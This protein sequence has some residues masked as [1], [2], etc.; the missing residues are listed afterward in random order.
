MSCDCIKDKNRQINALQAE[1]GRLQRALKKAKEKNASPSAITVNVAGDLD[2]HTLADRYNK[3]LTKAFRDTYALSA[4]PTTDD[5]KPLVRMADWEEAIARAQEAE[6]TAERYGRTI[7]KLV[8]ERRFLRAERDEAAREAEELGEAL[9]NVRPM[10]LMTAREH[11]DAAWE[12]AHVPANGVIPKGAE[13][14]ARRM[15]GRYA[16]GVG[17]AINVQEVGS[18]CRLIDAPT[19]TRP[20]GAEAIEAY[21]NEWNTDDAGSFSELA[22]FLAAKGVTA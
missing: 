20:D 9:D 8:E 6:A 12:A 7:D 2:P 15:N 13:F 14:I 3:R 5:R 16:L 18:E 10:D 11:L 22:D 21:I 17:T 1:K 19:P 4:A